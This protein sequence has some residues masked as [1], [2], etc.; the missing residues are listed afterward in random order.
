RESGLV[1]EGDR[2]FDVTVRVPDATR[3]NLDDIRSLPV[4]L[5]EVEGRPRAQVPLAQVAQIRLTEG[6]NQISRENGK[7]RVVVQVNLGGR[8]AGSFV[9]E[10]QAKIAQVKLPAGYY[11][12]WGGQFENLAAA[13]K[14]LSIV[15]P[16]CFLLIFGLLY[17]ALGGFGR[18]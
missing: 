5:P 8:D 9:Q 15:V 17:M 10:A 13:S 14:R 18:A 16:L 11:L 4:L 6:L 12:E 1:Y 3:A 2:R 7:R